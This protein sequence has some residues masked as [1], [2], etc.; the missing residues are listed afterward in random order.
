MD[1]LHFDGLL[2]QSH[3]KVIYT[4]QTE[5]VFNSVTTNYFFHEYV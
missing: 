5:T 3:Y 1:E 2:G 4:L